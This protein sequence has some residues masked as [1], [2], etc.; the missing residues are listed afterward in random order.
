[1]AIQLAMWMLHTVFAKYMLLGAGK[2]GL[3]GKKL[4]VS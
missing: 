3:V 2:A 4:K 1:M